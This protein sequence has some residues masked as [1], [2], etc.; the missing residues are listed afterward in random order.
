MTVPH[1]TELEWMISSSILT[2]EALYKLWTTTQS[3]MSHVKV[4]PQRP[5]PFFNV[6]ALPFLFQFHFALI[7]FS[8]TAKTVERWPR[9]HSFGKNDVTAGNVL[10][11]NSDV[12]ISKSSLFP[13]VLV[14]VLFPNIFGAIFTREF[15]DWWD[16]WTRKKE[17]NGLFWYRWRWKQK[18]RPKNEIR[19]KVTSC[20]RRDSLWSS[21]PSSRGSAVM[22]A[23]FQRQQNS[24]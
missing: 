10:W 4:P 7:L 13:V 15:L 8:K 3:H 18:Q 6:A 24:S 20:T 2:L 21:W 22:L 9:W 19:K 17:S 23:M 5:Q 1:H 14:T 16:W 11:G 12:T